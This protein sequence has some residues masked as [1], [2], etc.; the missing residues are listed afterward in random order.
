ME[1]LE[2]VAHLQAELG[3]QV[4]QGLVHEQHRGLRGQGAGDGHPLLLAAGQLGGVAVH[5][6]ADLY[7]AGDPAHGQV[8]LLF[9][10]LALFQHRLAVLQHPELVVQGLVLPG[11]GNF[12]F[13]SGDVGSGVLPGFQVIGKELFGGVDGEG[14]GIDELDVGPLLVQL[15]G[16]VPAVLQDLDHL[17]GGL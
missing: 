17:A 3:V 7:D 8:D 6:H 14:E 15:S 2:L 4:G 9:R 5:E 12:A 10:E 13:Q 1:P 11:G 16:F